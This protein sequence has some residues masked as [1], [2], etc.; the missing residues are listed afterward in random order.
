MKILAYILRDFFSSRLN[1]EPDPDATGD[2][3]ADSALTQGTH[4]EC[5]NLMAL[6]SLERGK[7]RMQ[8]ESD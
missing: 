6:V 8:L 2:E 7:G 5:E 1:T 4:Q 3:D